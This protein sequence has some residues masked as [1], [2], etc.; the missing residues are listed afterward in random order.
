MFNGYLDIEYKNIKIMK[1]IRNWKFWLIG[2]FGENSK[3]IKNLFKRVE[4]NN[5]LKHLSNY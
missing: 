3:I 4:K 5:E 2:V 1:T